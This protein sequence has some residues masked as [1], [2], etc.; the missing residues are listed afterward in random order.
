MFNNPFPSVP[1]EQEEEQLLQVLQNNPE[2]M[3]KY[4]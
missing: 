4:Q 2:L 1:K 3:K